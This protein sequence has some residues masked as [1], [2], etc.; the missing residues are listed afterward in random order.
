MRIDHFRYEIRSIS[1]RN[2]EFS[3]KNSVL[4]YEQPYESLKIDYEWYLNEQNI[5][6]KPK[7]GQI[8]PQDSVRF[9]VQL[10]PE[11]EKKYLLKPQLNYWS[12][13]TKI[14]QLT[15]R[16][17][18]EGVKGKI[19]AQAAFQIDTEHFDWWANQILVLYGAILKRSKRAHMLILGQSW[20][21]KKN[22]KN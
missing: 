17:I 21:E 7:T 18:G 9:T 20:F 11:E 1:I 14:E 5:H 4:A 19:S 8:K 22:S 15:V 3:M 16:C 13:G 12:E 6:I 10:Y 2:R